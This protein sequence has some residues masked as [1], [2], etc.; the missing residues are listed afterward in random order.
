[1]KKT[2]AGFTALEL[3]IVIG[4]IGVIVAIA[5]VGLTRA[6]AKSRDDSRISNM[7]SVQIALEDYKTACRNYPYALD[8]TADNCVFANGLTQFG[9]FLSTV[10]ANPSGTVFQYYAYAN[11]SDPELCVGYHLG[12]ALETENH[13]ALNTD[14][15]VNSLGNALGTIPCE[16]GN[17]TPFNGAVDDVTRIYDIYR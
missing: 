13:A 4:I 1:M 5:L 10:P 9:E 15:D 2:H 16:P 7:R 17:S 11:P 3:L 14:S 12:L 8:P 6:R